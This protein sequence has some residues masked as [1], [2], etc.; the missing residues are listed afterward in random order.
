MQCVCDFLALKTL[1]LNKFYG[2]SV[3]IKARTF[4]HFIL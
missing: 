1:K 2:L 3:F 4:N